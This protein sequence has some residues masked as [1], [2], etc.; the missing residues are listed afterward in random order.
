[1]KDAVR[2]VIAEWDESLHIA[3]RTY[4][5]LLGVTDPRAF[6]RHLPKIFPHGSTLLI[7]GLE[8]GASAKS[9]YCLHPSIYTRKV[10]CD[11]LSP[12]PESY[13]VEFS[14]GL[15]DRL[16]QLIE[17]Q[18]LAATFY[19]F[20]GYSEREVVFTFHD[21]FE[22][23]LVVSSGLSEKAVR[24]FAS[25]LGKTAEQARFPFDLREH[26]ETLDR[27]MNPPWWR[28]A[29]GIFQRKKDA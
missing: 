18:G 8:I 9:L 28:R 12:T 24:D 16:C 2:K 23:E 3:G 1:M 10:A 17:S 25:A 7:E 29:L 22:G 6:F 19:H 26:L 15:S 21:A 13:H 14:A 4:W 27:A 5:K 11:T 20:K